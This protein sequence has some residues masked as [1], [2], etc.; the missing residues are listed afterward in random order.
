MKTQAHRYNND[1]LER[2]GDVVPIRP[3]MALKPGPQGLCRPWRRL[4]SFIG[5][6][7]SRLLKV[8]DRHV[9]RKNRAGDQT[10]AHGGS[11]Q[12]SYRSM[13]ENWYHF[14]L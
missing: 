2:R 9:S 14:F 7:A 6:K 1:N 10:M 3:P 5:H 8:G 12:D 4:L 13:S 11:D